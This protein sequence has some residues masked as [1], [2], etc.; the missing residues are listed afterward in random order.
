[1]KVDD[2]TNRNKITSTGSIDQS[3]WIVRHRPFDNLFSFE[4]SPCLVEWDPNHNRWKVHLRI[5]DRFPFSA[6]DT[7]RLGRSLSFGGNANDPWA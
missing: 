6:E 7:F 1:M 5:H 4:L 2:V 3:G